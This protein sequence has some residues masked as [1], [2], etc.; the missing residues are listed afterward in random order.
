M[1]NSYNHLAE[2]LSE[3]SSH[4]TLSEAGKITDS[5]KGGTVCQ[6]SGKIEKQLVVDSPLKRYGER[7]V[8]KSHASHFL[9]TLDD[10]SLIDF[11]NRL[12]RKRDGLRQQEISGDHQSAAPDGKS[13]DTGGIL[14]IL[15]TT[16]DDVHH[17]TILS[18]QKSV[19]V[20]LDVIARHGNEIEQASFSLLK[21]S[22][23]G[24]LVLASSPGRSP[25]YYDRDEL[26]Q[27]DEQP[28]TASARLET[29]KLL[30]H[31]QIL[32]PSGN[33]EGA[34]LNY[35]FGDYG[36]YF[37]DKRNLQQR[38]DEQMK[39]YYEK[40]LNEGRAFPPIFKNCT[41][42]INGY[43]KPDRLQLHRKI[44]LHGGRF[45]HYMG[46]KRS[47]THI[48]A[49]NLTAK[50]RIEF[51]NSKVVT[52]EWI[53]NSVEAGKLLAWQDYALIQ[54]DYNQPKLPILTWNADRENG[55][56]DMDCKNPNFLE[57]FF[58][59][60]R[61]HQLSSWKAELRANFVDKF[62]ENTEFDPPRNSIPIMFHVDFDCFFATVSA[63]SS[64]C[65]S[66]DKDP[67]AVS[68]GVNS[69]DIASCNYV[70]RSFGVRNGMWVS[71]AKKMCPNLICLPYDFPQYEAKS[72]I[73]YKTLSEANV[74]D[75]IL[76]M[77]IDEA[78]CIKYK[79]KDMDE[80][81]LQIECGEICHLVMDDIKTATQGCT[82]SI[83]CGYSMVV[84]RLALKKSKPNG[85]SIGLYKDQ[86]KLD[87]FVFDFALRD[88]PGIGRSIID[89]IQEQVPGMAT[90]TKIG[91]LQQ[92]STADLLI[93]KLGHKTGNK[94]FSF[95]HGRDDEENMKILKNPKDYF[96]RKS[97]SVDINWGIRFDNIHQID[98]FVDRVC[99][100]LTTRIKE[101]GVISAHVVLKI[102]R[103]SKDAPTEPAKYLGMGKCESFSKSSR[104]GVATD[105]M[106]VIA[107]EVK[108]SLRMLGCPPKDLRGLSVQLLKLEKRRD[109]CK[110]AR[111]PF[112]QLKNEVPEPQTPGDILSQP[113]P[114]VDPSVYHS[115]PFELR[116]EVKSEFLKRSIEFPQ[117]LI[118]NVPRSNSPDKNHWRKFSKW[119]N[120]I[121]DEL[122][123][124]LDEEFLANLPSQLKR[125]IISEHL[126][127]KKTNS[128][129]L[130]ILKRKE[131]AKILGAQNPPFKGW[132][133][134]FEPVK[135]QNFNRPKEIL[136][137]V[138]Q[139]IS[140]TIVS[141]P[142]QDDMAMFDTYLKALCDAEKTHFILSISETVSQQ[143]DLH[144]KSDKVNQPGHQEWEEYLLR[145]II[146][147]LNRSA[148]SQGRVLDIIFDL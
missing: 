33:D 143:L 6:V 85:F 87:S 71:Q 118:P 123:S 99:E 119:P 80:V 144:S 88:L 104:L 3:S 133:S 145:K 72:N 34:N 93:S 98:L 124:S 65:Y 25:E 32:D 2:L 97:I 94:L 129:S 121:K 7:N 131:S 115:L 17:G 136:S 9:S 141:G 109:D 132:S 63:M 92:K 96:A 14:E 30:L 113:P 105:D 26:G 127:I 122:P 70:A 128:T 54:N 66:L 51:E 76:P 20:S 107:T 42:Y 27:H 112:K 120:R 59:K 79:D 106:G 134:L 16:Q 75:L 49:S 35:D 18:S 138:R 41:I 12:S 81:D 84:A 146:P 39:E 90:E 52:P 58:A 68:H 83:G 73:F 116:Q 36:T 28:D 147:T 130:K 101:L 64:G 139:W 103:R 111:L 21:Q 60:S 74:F 62:I 11:V 40:N 142:H 137:L 102:M 5:C 57:N 55:L 78:V 38:K 22:P 82:V 67:I 61:L 126:I 47:V 8:E 23:K 4:K 50:K 56:G 13:Q 44:V 140:E 89:K 86:E 46:S 1:D 117:K 48:V 108:S 125:E 10:D 148:S 100:N 29:S 15:E 95:I 19:D 110:Q 114:G 91:V 135:F 43:T 53:V 37:K 45:L 77:S 69:S 31:D 24:S